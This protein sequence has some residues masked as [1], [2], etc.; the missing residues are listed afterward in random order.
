M[1][2]KN[3]ERSAKGLLEYYADAGFT[4]PDN[5]DVESLAR[6][7]V[8]R[9][10]KVAFAGCIAAETPRRLGD[11]AES[12]DLAGDKYLSKG[13][14]NVYWSLWKRL[15][16][17]KHAPLPMEDLGEDEQWMYPP[18]T[19]LRLH[20]VAMRSEEAKRL[21]R[22][23]HWETWWSDTKPRLLA[24]RRALATFALRAERLKWGYRLVTNIGSEIE[25]V[26]G[27]FEMRDLRYDPDNYV[28]A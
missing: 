13:I 7:E 14:A 10:S 8:A 17:A 28:D 18:L 20:A 9:L 1:P 26:E 11:D 12:L 5:W 16:T 4:P 27:K 19:W 22:T 15:T 23:V 24:R 21:G 25:W 6:A 2:K 3:L